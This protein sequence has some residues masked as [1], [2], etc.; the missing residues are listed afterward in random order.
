[1]SCKTVQR[2]SEYLSY[3]SDS[4]HKDFSY[5][6]HRESKAK[7]KNQSLAYNSLLFQKLLRRKA[8]GEFKRVLCNK[9]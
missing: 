5:G 9:L 1:M 3:A 4:G 2:L 8:H 7:K 6:T